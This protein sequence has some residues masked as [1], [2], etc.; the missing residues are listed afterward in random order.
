ME[1]QIKLIF[2]R[3]LATFEKDLEKKI[4]EMVRRTNAAMKGL[5]EG[6]RVNGLPE[7]ATI[8]Y[9]E[10]FITITG[11]DEDRMVLKTAYS[12]YQSISKNKKVDTKQAFAKY[13]RSIGT[14]VKYGTNNVTMIVGVKEKDAWD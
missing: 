5:A 7:I 3:E 8:D 11:N 14:Q 4:L 9:V 2:Q 6:Q 1:N 10:D 12:N 13:L